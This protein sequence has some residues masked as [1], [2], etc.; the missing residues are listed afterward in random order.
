M[1]AKVVTF[2]PDSVSGMTLMDDGSICLWSEGRSSSIDVFRNGTGRD[3]A[4]DADDPLTQAIDGDEDTQYR[5]MTP[6]EVAIYDALRGTGWAC[7]ASKK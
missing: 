3:V 4:V 2:H 6:F 5:D 7:Q 1:K